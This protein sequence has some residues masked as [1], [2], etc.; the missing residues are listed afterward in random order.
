MSTVKKLSTVLT[1][2][3]VK[4]E[5]FVTLSDAGVP[6]HI[7]RETTFPEGTL[8]GNAGITRIFHGKDLET[9]DIF[10]SI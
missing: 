6:L 7:S 1:S 10:C 2:Q 4:V 5:N 8:L 9:G 3:N